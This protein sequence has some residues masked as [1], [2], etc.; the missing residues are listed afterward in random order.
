MVEETK[1]IVTCR[2]G[3]PFGIPPKTRTSF[4]NNR[5]PTPNLEA[6]QILIHN[7]ITFTS[8]PIPVSLWQ[9]DAHEG[10]PRKLFRS[11]VGAPFFCGQASWWPSQHVSRSICLRR[12]SLFFHVCAAR[13]PALLQFFFLPWCW[14]I[15]PAVPVHGYRIFAGIVLHHACVPS[16]F[17]TQPRVR[18]DLL[19]FDLFGVVRL[20]FSVRVY[21]NI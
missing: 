5:K 2:E 12:V 7:D 17:S 8:P 9:F 14:V 15:A 1:T 13:A 16:I 21:P 10:N 11:T 20:R 19:P 4:L 18:S 3:L 6:D